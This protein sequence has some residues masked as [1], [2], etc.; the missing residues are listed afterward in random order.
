MSRS[1]CAPARRPN[2]CAALEALALDVVLTNLAPARDAASHWLV[3]RIDEQPVSLIGTPRAGRRADRAA[4][5]SAGDA[6]P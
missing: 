4:G 5:G 6:S 1:C 2:F 3:H